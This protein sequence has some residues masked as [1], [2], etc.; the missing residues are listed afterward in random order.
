MEVIVRNLGLFSNTRVQVV[1]SEISKRLGEVKGTLSKEVLGN[2]PAAIALGGPDDGKVFSLRDSTV[3]IGR[4][5]PNTPHHTA[6][7][8]ISSSPTVTLP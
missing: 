7:I 5:D 8:P 3:S 4:N 1:G 2:V 6:L